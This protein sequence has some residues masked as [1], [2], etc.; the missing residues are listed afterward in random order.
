MA[1]SCTSFASVWT[2]SQGSTN[3]VCHI[4]MYAYFYLC[5]HDFGYEYIDTYA[6]LFPRI[7]PS[8][9]CP[10]DG[11]NNSI[12]KDSLSFQTQSSQKFIL[13]HIGVELSFKIN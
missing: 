6:H 10:V 5:T 4:R 12:F 9:L 7:Y 8:N 1:F 3:G 13:N 11:T 2:L